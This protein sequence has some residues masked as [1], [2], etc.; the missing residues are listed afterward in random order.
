[1]TKSDFRIVLHE[2]DHYIQNKIGEDQWNHDA[3]AYPSQL[4]AETQIEK[5]IND[6]NYVKPE[7]ETPE[8][9]V[10]KTF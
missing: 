4:A 7:V 3:A 2:G 6:H 1:M 10:V 9:V 5:F 8:W